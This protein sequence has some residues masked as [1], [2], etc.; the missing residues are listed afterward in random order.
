MYKLASI[1]YMVIATVAF[2]LMLLVH[3][4]WNFNE[5]VKEYKR[6]YRQKHYGAFSSDSVPSG[7]NNFKDIVATAKDWE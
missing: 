2:P 7:A 6:L 4:V 3:G 1:P 5:L